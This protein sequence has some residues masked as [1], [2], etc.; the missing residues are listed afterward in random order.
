MPSTSS[1]TRI[2]LG[3]RARVEGDEARQVRVR[4]HG[5]ERAGL[6]A[7]HLEE[8][9][10]GEAARRG[11]GVLGDLEREAL[12]VGFALVL[13]ARRDEHASRLRRRRARAARRSRR[14]CG[15]RGATPAAPRVTRTLDRRAVEA[16]GRR[17]AARPGAT[18]RRPPRA[19]RC[20]FGTSPAGARRARAAIAC[21]P[22][23]ALGPGEHARH[24]ERR[25]AARRAWRGATSARVRAR[26]A[27]RAPTASWASD[28]EREPR[29]RSRP[30]ARC[31]LRRQGAQE[32]RWTSRRAPRADARAPCAAPRCGPRRRARGPAPAR[33]GG[34]L[35]AWSGVAGASSLGTIGSSSRRPR[36]SGVPRRRRTGRTAIEHVHQIGFIDASA[37][38][39]E[40]GGV[41]DG[42]RRPRGGC[43]STSQAPT[44]TS[45][46][47]ARAT[48]AMTVRRTGE[49]GSR[50]N[51]STSARATSERLR[52]RRRAAPRRRR[53][54]RRRPGAA[55]SRSRR[56]PASRGRGWACCTSG[57][58]AREDPL[59]QPVAQRVEAPPR[60]SWPRLRPLPARAGAPRTSRSSKLM[61]RSRRTARE[62]RRAM[63]PA[64]PRRSLSCSLAD[65]LERDDRAAG[66]A[67]S[68][69]RARP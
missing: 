37:S 34:E 64:R 5:D 48:A 51:R 2:G 21:S 31:S 15:A 35:L 16:C 46:S 11:G 18:P 26:G 62:V 27:A 55:A 22:S 69:S 47:S 9:G 17:R 32:A 20:G 19:C 8:L 14:A 43:R 58:L 30:P 52:S 41:R 13:D 63:E 28:I 6:L 68:T 33:R 45:A 40:L 7:E 42:A 56:R 60:R 67:A 29:A 24:R 1:I 50:S 61:S 12:G 59:G 66:R 3:L 57:R 49:G 44:R 38:V 53:P 23:V 25:A 4:G 36:A 39:A 54:C 10:L 65:R